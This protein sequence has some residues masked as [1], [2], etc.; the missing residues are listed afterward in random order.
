MKIM[1]TAIIAA[2]ALVHSGFALADHHGKHGRDAYED[3]EY[4]RD[5]GSG[6]DYAT[7]LRSVPVTERVRISRPTQQCWDESVP[8]ETPSSGSSSMTG[9]IVG[10]IIGAA[11]GNA[12][13]HSN[14]NKKVGAVAGG[15][16]GASVGHDISSRNSGSTV[17][18]ETQQRCDNSEAVSYEDRVVAYDVTYRYRNQTRTTRMDHDP[19]NSMRVR[20]DVTPAE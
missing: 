10:G 15:V 16:L 7:V 9:T 8:V 12:V 5:A 17:H 13:G 19:G 6:Y 1:T 20:V 2:F 14:T 18:Y 3:E 4:Y 11:I